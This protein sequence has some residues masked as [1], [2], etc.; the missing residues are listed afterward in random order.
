MAAA[1]VREAE[2]EN[3][4]SNHEFK[5]CWQINSKGKNRKEQR[6]PTQSCQKGVLHINDISQR[7]PGIGIG[8]P[9]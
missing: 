8:V 3:K 5:G 7:T 2:N 6:T 9:T 4:N 1:A